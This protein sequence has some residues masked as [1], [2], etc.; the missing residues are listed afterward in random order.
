[1]NEQTEWPA[2]CFYFWRQRSF[3]RRLMT[4]IVVMLLLGSGLY[5]TLRLPVVQR[6]SGG[7]ILLAQT[8]RIHFEQIA[9]TYFGREV[10]LRQRT[11][12]LLQQLDSEIERLHWLE[13]ESTT[14]AV[15]LETNLQ[16]LRNQQT[17][18]R[19]G[20]HQLAD[21]VNQGELTGANGQP[22]NA[23]QTAALVAEKLQIFAA[24]QAQVA[25]YQQSA[26]LHA[27]TAIRAAQLQ[28][29]AHAQTATLSAY[30][31]LFEST[32]QLAE[33]TGPAIDEQF[34]AIRAA[35]QTQ[36]AHSE[37]V[38]TARQALE[39][40]LNNAAVDLEAVD[41]LLLDSAEFAAQLHR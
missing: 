6:I 25:L 37:H 9:T 29:E 14:M 7:V 27:A 41:R 35:L 12:Y 15:M 2:Q 36:L 23:A 4:V 8:L 17:A 22:L 3:G 21:T 30:L 19:L 16:P 28:T 5:F 18:A 39:K 31:A 34:A 26:Q 33:R 13:V 40:R 1:M 20:L 24:L 11:R 38:T 10:L 32:G